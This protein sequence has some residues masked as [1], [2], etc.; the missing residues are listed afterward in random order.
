MLKEV[1]EFNEKNAAK[2]MPFWAREFSEGRR[3]RAADH[4]EYVDAIKKNH[5][6]AGKK[7]SMRRWT[8]TNWMPSLRRPA[9]A[10]LTDRE[11]RL[12]WRRSSEFA[13]VTGYPNVNV[14]ADSC[15]VASRHFVLGGRGANRF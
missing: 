10:W 2:E 9:A 7:G 14:V 4:A 12:V 15:A 6:L 8:S 1:I 13:A 11:R 3:K 5:E